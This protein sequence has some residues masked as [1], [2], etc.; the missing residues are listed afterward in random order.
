M[1]FNADL[2]VAALLRLQ[3]GVWALELKSMEFLIYIKKK[4]YACQRKNMWNYVENEKVMWYTTV[5]D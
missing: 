3:S 5:G 4:G 1:T 2:H